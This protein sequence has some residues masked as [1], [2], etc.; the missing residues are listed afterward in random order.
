MIKV[1]YIM[2]VCYM[3]ILDNYLPKTSFGPGI[4]DVGAVRFFS[5]LIVIA[6]G[7]ETAITKQNKF[8]FKWIGI[9]SIF[10]LIT[11][12]SVSWSNYSYSPAVIQ[13]I[14]NTILIPLILAIIGLNIFSERDNIDA[15]IKNILIAAI[16][17][18]FINIFQILFFKSLVLGEVRSVGT[19]GNPNLSAIF[20]VLIIPCLIYAVEKQIVSRIFGW[21]VSVSL[22][23]GIICTVSRKGMATCIL[24]FSLYYFLKGKIKKVF[25]LGFVVVLMTIFLSG[26]AVISGRFSQEAMDKQLSG[27]WAMTVAGWEM[28]KESPL[29]G[30]GWEGYYENFG[31]Y[32]QWSSQEKYDAHNEFITALANYGLIGFIPFLCI[33]LYPLFVARKK[34]KAD[35]SENSDNESKELAIVCISSI[36][37]FML[38]GWFAG[39][40]FYS[41]AV[42]VLLYANISLF[43]SSRK[44]S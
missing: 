18:S 26:Y 15:F 8:F 13:E 30:L 35:S 39:G 1:L 24:A 3:P 14:F 11:M 25:A 28:F 12:A 4:P 23:V 9:I 40:L 32:F 44:T 42:V 31:R 16:I 17:L 20:L 34:L 41:P 36:I 7:I 43:L 29:I 6:F 27:K 33:F 19:L 37:P 10:S 5:Y 22:V 2:L 21:V 38:N